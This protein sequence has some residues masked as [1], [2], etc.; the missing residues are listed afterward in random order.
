MYIYIYT[1]VCV[2]VCIGFTPVCPS[3]LGGRKLFRR[4]VWVNP[5]ADR[6][7]SLSINF[8]FTPVWKWYAPSSRHL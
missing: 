3:F 1:Y 2:C 5:C 7:I 4:A 8:G 6:S